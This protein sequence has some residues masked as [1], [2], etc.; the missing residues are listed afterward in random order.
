MLAL[1][2]CCVKIIYVSDRDGRRLRRNAGREE[3]PGSAG[4]GC[5]ITSGGGDPR[6]SATENNRRASGKG[7]K[8]GQEPT[9]LAVT[10]GVNVNP[11]RS[12]TKK[13]GNCLGKV[14]ERRLPAVSR[15]VGRLR[16]QAT[17]V[18]ER[19]PFHTEPGLLV[20]HA[21]LFLF[22]LV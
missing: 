3:S 5:R 7:E 15:K 19:W 20:T 13:G 12:K 11:I 18:L 14:P 2:I 22:L 17:A 4:Q 1:L 9:G 16:P 10:S 21:F 8:A 6:E